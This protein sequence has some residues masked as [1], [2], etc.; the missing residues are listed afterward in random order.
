MAVSAKNFRFI[1]PGIRIE[2]IDRSQIPADDPAIGACVIGR[3]RRGPAFTPVEVRSFS[4]FVSTFGEPVAGGNGGDVWREGNY[5]S[6]M[7]ATYA[8]QSWLRNGEALT[9]VRTLGVESDNK[10]TGGE[11]GWK[12][13]TA[14]FKAAFNTSDNS[15]GAYALVVAPSGTIGSSHTASVAAVWYLEQGSMFLSGTTVSAGPAGAVGTPLASSSIILQT[16]GAKF[17]VGFQSG[18]SLPSGI[19]EFDFNK[20]SSTY[21]R[22]VF[23]TDPTLLG[24]NGTSNGEVKYF[25]GETFENSVPTTASYF[26]AIVGLGT[27]TLGSLTDVVQHDVQKAALE[28]STYAK[29]GW[30]LSQ[31][32]SSDTSSWSST[33]P[34]SNITNGRIKKL[35]R[36]VGLDSGEWTQQNLKISVSNIRA[37]VNEDVNP[38]GTFD[39]VVRRLNDS[40]DNKQVVESFSGCNLNPNSDDYILNKIGDKYNTFDESSN[41]VIEKGGY[42]NRSRYI[43]VEVNPEFEAG[44]PSDYAVF[45]VTGP[46]KFVD[47]VFNTTSQSGSG[48]LVGGLGDYLGSNNLSGQILSGTIAMG[49]FRIG[50][51]S[52]TTR[53]NTSN[54]EDFR[55]AHFGALPTPDKSDNF[56]AD[57]LDL[58]R[59]KPVNVTNQYDAVASELEYQYI[60]FLDNVIINGAVAGASTSSLQ[61]SASVLAYDTGSRKGGYSLSST[62]SYPSNF[63]YG[64]SGDAASYKAVLNAGAGN[65]TTLFFGGT[66]GWDI[67]KSDPLAQNEIATKTINDRF[68]SYE[69]FTYYR[70]IETVANPE[71][72]SYN[73]VSVPGL[74]NESLTNQLIANTAERADALAVFDIPFGYIPTQE[75]LYA[76]ANNFNLGSNSNGD[77]NQAINEV[78]DR[79]YNSSY[80]ATYYPWVKIRDSINSKDVWVPPSIAA[81][82]AMS[83][84]DRVQAPWFAPAGFN[85]GGLSTGVS[86]LPVVS[87]A[88]KLF[89]DDRDDLYEVGVNPIATFPNEGVVIFGQKTLQVERSALDRINVRRLLI[90]L[91]RGISIIS[92]RILFEPN[93]PDTWDNFKR[94]AIPFLTDVKTRYGL[95]DYKLVLDETTTTPD[96]IDQNIL[97]AKLFIKPARA[98]EYIALDFIITN[99]GASFDD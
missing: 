46:T 22:K 2:E 20:G 4:D 61:A 32:L 31:D 49:G 45:G 39:V 66:D 95:T 17:K 1:S 98:I 54:L 65:L 6:P 93:V 43:R 79:K 33:D 57:T 67:T 58:V 89:K 94:Q 51:P 52:A 97:Y 9:F 55:M 53:T 75:R 40:D 15:G 47:T 25:L 38:Y 86:G 21:V 63:N 48:G 56:K 5:T 76:A 11:A 16:S 12:V 28:S 41:R 35:F 18:Q 14:N 8:A 91:K 60:T 74:I 50:F 7:Y 10:I 83:Y 92:N 99:T 85:R 62:G 80:A 13:G 70:A 27:G 72:V 77:I 68:S 30:F 19:F 24:R 90:F 84:T 3:S 34:A 78:K 81:L 73:V 44:F 88:L 37:P 36:F 96:L 71:Q 87:T 23:N 82:G 64:P 69:T 29:S 59:I 26:A 42:T